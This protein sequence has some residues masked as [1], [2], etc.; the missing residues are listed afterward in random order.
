MLRQ[1]RPRLLDP[2][3]LAWLRRQRCACGCLQAPPCDAAHLRSRS[4]KYDKESGSGKPDDRWALPLK[5]DHH[6]AQHRCNELQ[7][8][9]DHG[10]KD[11]FALCIEH[12]QRYLK[13]QEHD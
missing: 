1:R 9:R 3:Y 12:Y 4:L 13:E 10:V 11:P 5:H 7:W 2:K 8:W 6:M